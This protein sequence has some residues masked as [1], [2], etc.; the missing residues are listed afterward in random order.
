M[1]LDEANAVGL[2]SDY[3]FGT[4]GELLK[5]TVA[6]SVN[7]VSTAPWCFQCASRAAKPPSCGDWFRARTCDTLLAEERSFHSKGNCGGRHF[8]KGRFLS[9]P[10]ERNGRSINSPLTHWALVCEWECGKVLQLPWHL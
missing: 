2:A 7:I 8:S 6:Y 3:T 10:P 1:K 9:L 4:V 5:P